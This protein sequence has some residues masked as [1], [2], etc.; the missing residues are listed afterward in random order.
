M[1]KGD[2]VLITGA[3][4]GIGEAFARELTSQGLHA[5]LVARSESKLRSLAGELSHAYNVNVEAIPQDLTEPGAALKIKKRLVEKGIQID[6]LINNAG[7]GLRGAFLDSRAIDD[8]SQIAVNVS[9]VVS[10]CRTFAPD[11]VSRGRGSI[12]NV[13]SLAGFP[14]TPYFA[15]YGASKAFVLHFS[16]ALAEELRSKGV[17]VLTLCPGAAE[18]GFFKVS[19]EVP[20][21]ERR[22]S[23]QDVVAT[24]L[25]AL[26]KSGPLAIDGSSNRV[27]ARLVSLFSK[28][29]A[30]RLMSRFSK[31]KQ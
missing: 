21:A 27:K 19:G 4:S 20:G 22:R 29:L 1:H 5:V 12:V 28:P 3:S 17:R 9:A 8:E 15:V 2:T 14:P 6:H 18:T 7:F 16:I 26:K 13:S 11:F 10:F 25:R 30:A 24:A 31:P 23:A